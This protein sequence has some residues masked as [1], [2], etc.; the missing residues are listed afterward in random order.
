MTLE[1]EV[2]KLPMEYRSQVGQDPIVRTLIRHNQPLT[3]KNYLIEAVNGMSQTP[4]Q[5]TLD[6]LTPDW[7]SI[8]PKK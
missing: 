7:L 3:Q 2:L 8:L 6:F 1:Q 5:E 4:T